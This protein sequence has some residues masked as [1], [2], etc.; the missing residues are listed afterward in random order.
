MGFAVDNLRITVQSVPRVSWGVM[1][2]LVLANVVLVALR[3]GG[4]DAALRE[5]RAVCA[6]PPRVLGLRNEGAGRVSLRNCRGGAPSAAGAAVDLS[7]VQLW[8]CVR[9]EAE[10]RWVARG[11]AHLFPHINFITTDPAMRAH[12]RE[13]T[14]RI[15]GRDYRVVVTNSKEAGIHETLLLKL[16]KYVLWSCQ[17]DAEQRQQNE[18]DANAT[19]G[20]PRGVDWVLRF[21]TDTVMFPARLSQYLATHDAGAATMTGHIFRNQQPKVRDRSFKIRMTWPNGGAG[22]LYTR[23]AQ[24]RMC[25]ALAAQ[26]PPDEAVRYSWDDVILGRMAGLGGVAFVD[27]R[28][29]FGWYP[30]GNKRYLNNRAAMDS[31]VTTHNIDYVPDIQDLSILFNEVFRI[32]DDWPRLL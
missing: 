22:V 17:P 23:G 1:A 3:G 10:M 11:W 30:P 31:L 25:A 16:Y 12:Y 19:V 29:H 32:N 2:L 28:T 21:D 8:T 7:R 27:D 4:E 6:D 24:A 15:D 20:T 14:R 26:F 13:E 9:G 18:Q 5:R